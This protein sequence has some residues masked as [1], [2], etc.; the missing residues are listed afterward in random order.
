MGFDWI[1]FLSVWQTG[2]AAQG[3]SR[4]KPEWH[5][6]FAQTLPVMI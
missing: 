2:P 5:R 4:A 3:I 1:W 6:E